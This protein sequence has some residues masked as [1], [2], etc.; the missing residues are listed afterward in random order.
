MKKIILATVFALAASLSQAQGHRING[1]GTLKLGSNVSIMEEFGFIVKATDYSDVLKYS[2]YTCELMGDTNSTSQPTIYGKADPRARVFIVPKVKLTESI[3]IK[4][5]FLTFLNDTL[6]GIQC[7]Y[8][9]DLNSALD[10][11]YGKSELQSQKEPHKFTRTYTG[12]EITLT[13]ETFTNKWGDNK[14]ECT[15]TF[16]KYYSG[17]IEAKYLTYFYL[18]NKNAIESIDKASG[19]CKERARIRK[20]EEKKKELGSL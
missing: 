18:A 9:S 13:D 7:D 15:S 17:S 1:L 19:E 20:E 3:E 12:E 6:V 10:L 2:K 8:N 4:K 5:V 16:M 11:K 14:I